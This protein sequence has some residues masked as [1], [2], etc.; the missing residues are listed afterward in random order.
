MAVSLSLVKMQ[1]SVEEKIVFTLIVFLVEITLI[2]NAG[3]K[4]SRGR[5]DHNMK[6]DIIIIITGG[7]F[8]TYAL[9]LVMKDPPDV[10][11]VNTQCTSKRFPLSNFYNDGVS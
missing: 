7:S 10:L 9:A 4:C 5:V 6:S 3:K 11:N 8:I 2:Y 1:Y